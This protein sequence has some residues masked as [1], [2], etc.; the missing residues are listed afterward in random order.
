[1]GLDLK[2][3]FL[4]CFLNIFWHKLKKLTGSLQRW[5]SRKIERNAGRG[6]VNAAEVNSQLIGADWE[7]KFKKK[8]AGSNVKET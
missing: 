4:N 8:L 5:K 3:K 1:M 2:N 6:N 7:N